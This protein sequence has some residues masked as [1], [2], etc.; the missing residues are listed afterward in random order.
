M[1]QDTGV[2][3]R[4]RPADALGAGSDTLQQKHTERVTNTRHQLTAH[5]TQHDATSLQQTHAPVVG[6]LQL[7]C[8]CSTLLITPVVVVVDKWRKEAA[9]AGREH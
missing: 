5:A 2:G 7:L 3:T 9:A 1:G 6:L 4:Y 8:R